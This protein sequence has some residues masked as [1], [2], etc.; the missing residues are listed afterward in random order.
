V[1]G[2]VY[3]ELVEL[4]N[5]RHGFVTPGDA[6]KAGINP[7]NLVR[8]A[9]RGQ[10]ERRANGLYRFPLVPSGPLDAYMEATLW[11]RGACGVLSHETAFDLYEMSDVHPRKIH[12]TI[13]KAH[14]VRRVAPSSYRFHREDLKPEQVT[15][16]EG[17]P[18]VT[19]VHAV[20]QA[21]RAHLGPA[22]LAQAIDQGQR[23][24]RL[25]VRQAKELRAEIGASRGDGNR[26]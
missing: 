25:T 1:P 22:L 4:A 13:P 12:V 14:R 17:I 26:R 2:K 5:E 15:R 8:M 6:R 20:R 23:N 10:L 3:S 11:P 7:M 16:F 24:G 19:P 18:M 9:E 21:H